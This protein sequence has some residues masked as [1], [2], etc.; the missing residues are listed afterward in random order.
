MTHEIAQSIVAKGGGGGGVRYLL[1]WIK[2]LV[3]DCDILLASCD[4]NREKHMVYKHVT[5]EVRKVQIV[6][7]FIS[8]IVRSRLVC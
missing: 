4:A 5:L 8:T 7:I 2:L 3:N 1:W 6:T